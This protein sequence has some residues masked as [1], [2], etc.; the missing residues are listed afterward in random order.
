MDVDESRHL[1]RTCLI[2]VNSFSQIESLDYKRMYKK[3]QPGNRKCLL[4]WKV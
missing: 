2:N 3:I 1:Y 4:E